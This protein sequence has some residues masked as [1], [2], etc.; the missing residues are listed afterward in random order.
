MVLE[1]EI[2]NWVEFILANSLG[3]THCLLRRTR[4]AS[5][6]R[7]HCR[8]C[9]KVFPKTAAPENCDCCWKRMFSLPEHHHYVYIMFQQSATRRFLSE[10]FVNCFDVNWNRSQW[11][12]WSSCSPLKLAIKSHQ[13]TSGGKHRIYNCCDKQYERET[14]VKSTYIAF[15]CEYMRLC[16]TEAF[17]Q[18]SIL[19]Q[20]PNH[21][22]ATK[23]IPDSPT[24][25]SSPGFDIILGTVVNCIQHKNTSHATKKTMTLHRF[26]NRLY[27]IFS[28]QTEMRRIMMEHNSESFWLVVYIGPDL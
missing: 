28:H 21:P 20:P 16:V 9:L 22:S 8:T 13:D 23:A 7:R 17:V 24:K 15:R 11:G 6:N 12:G 1:F 26:R 4:L 18:Y 19:A 10:N 14:K 5:G 2:I 27:Y 25:R 3:Q